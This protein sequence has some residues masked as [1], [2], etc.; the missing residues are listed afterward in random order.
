MT[1]AE[2]IRA[3]L[4]RHPDA[5]DSTVASH[6]DVS[7]KAVYNVRKAMNGQKT[8]PTPLHCGRDGSGNWV[9]LVNGRVWQ[10][11]KDEEAAR[12]EAEFLRWPKEPAA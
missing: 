8:Q 1:K 5:G 4:E 2:K 6:L 10:E 12:A 3:F 9:V 7:R 11:F